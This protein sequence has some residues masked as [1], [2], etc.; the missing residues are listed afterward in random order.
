MGKVWD[1]E[2]ISGF[3]GCSFSDQVESVDQILG[4][5]LEWVVEPYD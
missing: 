2:E 3:V 1:K 5:Q 4:G